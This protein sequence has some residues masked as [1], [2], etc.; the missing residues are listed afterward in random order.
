MWR[1]IEYGIELLKLGV[2][3]R[4]GDGES[5]CIWR[6]NWISRPLRLKPTGST[7][8]CRLRRVSQLLSPGCNE[9]DIGTLRRFF[10]PWD[11]DEIRKIKLP[12]HKTPD[13]VAWNY[14]RTGVFLVR[15]A[16]RMA[17]SKAMNLD[18]RG[19]SAEGNGER[20]VWKKIRRLPVLPKV[21]N[22][23]W[24]LVRN[25]LPTSE[26]RCHRHIAKEAGC[27]LC[28][29]RCE[30]GF[31]AVMT[32]TH[33]RALRM[34]M[35]EIWALPPE[36]RLYN[37]GPEWF[38]LV[39][40]DSYDMG[41]VANPAMVLWRAWSFQNKVTRAGAALSIEASIDYLRR[42]G[43]E[44]HTT[45]EATGARHNGRSNRG[46]VRPSQN[47]PGSYWVPPLH[48]TIKINV[49][50]AFNPVSGE[51]AVGVIARDHG[52]N[53]VVMAWRMISDCRD[54]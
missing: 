30:D 13:W 41:E 31:H 1:E 5:T 2:I 7:R 27:E 46:P 43:E 40:L 36:E 37:D 17:L 50:G 6:D 18:E 11:V 39:L 15:S 19:S 3:H 22:F 34:A 42:L 47:G 52:G 48:G 32:C 14:E 53:P 21:R 38:F 16:Y 23:I 54:A 9:W 51:A 28:Y 33:A 25:G 26:S 10:S 35:R 29:H 8:T 44:L 20:K 49:D 45:R 12:T 24:K 4:I